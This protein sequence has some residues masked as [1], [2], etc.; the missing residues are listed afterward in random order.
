M[1]SFDRRQYQ[2][3]FNFARNVFFTVESK[4][5][6]ME[7]QAAEIM[8]LCEEVLGQQSTFPKEAREVLSEGTDDDL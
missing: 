3:V 4:D 6:E 1:S 5:L 7:L 2:T 8:A